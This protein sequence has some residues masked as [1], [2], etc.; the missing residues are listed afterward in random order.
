M[1][2]RLALPFVLLLVLLNFATEQA[3]CSGMA[4]IKTLQP[5]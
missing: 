5:A 4:R 1:A 3:M 2:L